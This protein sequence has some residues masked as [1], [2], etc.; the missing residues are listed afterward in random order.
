MRLQFL[1]PLFSLFLLALG[2]VEDNIYIRTE[3]DIVNI[4]EDTKQFEN[5]V[6]LFLPN[7]TFDNGDVIVRGPAAIEALL[8]STVYFPG[9]ITQSASTT[10]VIQLDPA[11][12][13]LGAASTAN[14]TTYVTT[15]FVGQ[16][17][18]SG[19]TQSFFGVFHDTFIKTGDFPIFG[20][21]KFSSR[22]FTSIVSFLTAFHFFFPR[23]N[24]RLLLHLGLLLLL[25]RPLPWSHPSPYP[26]P[27]VPTLSRLH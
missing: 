1:A 24:E 16:G 5:F 17:A 12:D 3:I 27:P 20:G 23:L 10:S 19:Q 22:K 21:W 13:P 25:R 7:A 6:N 4:L 8:S 2:S 9:T 15:T 11:F 18:T 26:L 14:S